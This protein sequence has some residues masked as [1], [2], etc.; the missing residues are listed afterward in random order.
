MPGNEKVEYD[1]DHIFPINGSDFLCRFVLRGSESYVSPK[2]D[3]GSIGALDIS[4][5]AIVNMDIQD[6]LFEPFT[7]G[8][9]TLNNPFDFIDDNVK[10]TGD[11]KD[12][13]EVTLED[14]SE[15]TT[16]KF[17]KKYKEEELRF[18][19]RALKYKFVV[20]DENNNTSKTD[21]SNNFKTYTLLE[22]SYFRMNEKIPYGKR[23]NGLV[24][25]IIQQVL[26]EFGFTIDSDR[27]EPGNHEID[28]FPEYIIPPST[29]RY[30]DLIKYL[31]RIYYYKD[32]AAGLPVQGILK[33]D[34]AD[35]DNIEGK[36]TLQP[37][38]KIYE[39]NK[40]L[41]IE[42]FGVQ[43]LINNESE[44]GNPN[45]PAGGNHVPVNQFTNQLKNT[46]LTS[47]LTK[48]VDEF[49]INYTVDSVDPESG[50]HSKDIIRF[51]DDGV[52][53][54]K[55]KWIKTFVEC[56]ECLG[57]APK[58]HLVFNK[59][60]EE[61]YKPYRTPFTPLKS[62]NL[63]IAQLVSNLLFFNLNLNFE[64]IGD[65]NRRSGTF[66]DVFRKGNNKKE[67]KSELSSAGLTDPKLLGRW[68]VCKVRHRFLK[69]KYQTVVQ[70]VKSCIGPDDFMQKQIKQIEKVVKD[71][72]TAVNIS[73]SL[74]S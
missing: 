46:N 65:T 13:L 34:R 71:F 51:R 21:R 38:T 57:G 16:D 41:V 3:G 56:F 62:K 35:M 52:D 6:S 4:K 69:D 14:T 11:G 55:E 67:E 20:L 58:P 26:E 27:W 49:F 64:Q 31:L 18:N 44:Q 33:Q 53:N 28:I 61:K 1:P 63:A 73:S 24:G 50:G 36:F 72:P 48:F 23:Y 30:S 29:F 45:N 25:D 17:V 74:V 9:I 47:P 5:S 37:L 12:L 39:N 19:T 40:K 54:I 7:S 42:A 22:E 43:D 2:P 66:I 10:L 32:G 15:R 8:T 70:C 59:K 60:T 68:L